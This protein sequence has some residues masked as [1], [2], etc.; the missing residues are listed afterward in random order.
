M[1]ILV[2]TGRQD[3][4]CFAR[5]VRALLEAMTISARDEVVVT[6]PLYRSGVRYARESGSR[7]TFL[8]PLIVAERGEGDCAHLCLWRCAELRNAGSAATYDIYIQER[9][10]SRLFHV[11]LRLP[12]GAIEDPSIKLGM[13]V[14]AGLK[15]PQ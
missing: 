8:S 3:S 9:T 12:S 4:E 2:A 10:V 11:R 1:R 15:V 6:G 5:S 7:E 13:P 14:P